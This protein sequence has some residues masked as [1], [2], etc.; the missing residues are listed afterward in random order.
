MAT[1]RASMKAPCMEYKAKF[2][3]SELEK[4]KLTQTYDDG[5]TK[6]KKAPIFTGIEGIEGLLYV[7]EHFRSI[8]NTLQFEDTELF[9]NFAECLTDTAEEKW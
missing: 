5:S 2:K 3:H 9:D 8:A 7:E 1:L 4:V 6:T